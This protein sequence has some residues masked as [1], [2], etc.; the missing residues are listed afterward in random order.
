M[1]WVKIPPDQVPHLP[2]FGIDLIKDEGQFAW[3]RGERGRMRIDKTEPCVWV[4]DISDALQ[5]KALDILV[6]PEATE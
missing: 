1:P 5:L 2:L 3:Y 4:G 6:E